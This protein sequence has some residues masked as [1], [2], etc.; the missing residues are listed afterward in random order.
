MWLLLSSPSSSFLFSLKFCC[1][2]LKKKKKN[3][4]SLIHQSSIPMCL[5]IERAKCTVTEKQESVMQAPSCYHLSSS[6]TD[7]TQA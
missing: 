3:F 4:L 2:G 5:A 7:Y 1:L 6:L